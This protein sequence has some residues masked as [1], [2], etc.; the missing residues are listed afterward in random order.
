MVV[1]IAFAGGEMAGAG[2]G[3]GLIWAAATDERL[4]AART[5]VSAWRMCIIS[6]AGAE[7]K[8]IFRTLK[9]A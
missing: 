1:A 8:A 7:H 6:L 5:A 3:A 4:T 9:G 2:T